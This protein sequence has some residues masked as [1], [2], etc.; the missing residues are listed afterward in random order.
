MPFTSNAQR[1]MMYSRHP[2]VAKRFEK[3]TPTGKKLPERASGRLSAMYAKM[4][5]K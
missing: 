5:K 1:R 3:E 4:S 2:E